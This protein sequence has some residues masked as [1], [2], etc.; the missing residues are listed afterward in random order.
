MSSC[1]CHISAS[2]MASMAASARVS[3][4]PP[5]ISA[6]LSA[7]ASLAVGMNPERPDLKLALIAPTLP[8]VSIAISPPMVQV[9]AMLSMGGGS[10]T[11]ADLPTLEA[12]LHVMANSINNY[13]TPSFAAC[14]SVDISALLELSAAAQMILDLK[15]AG[16]DPLEASFA[17][18]VGNMVAAAPP[19]IG[20]A[21][22]APQM[23]NIKILASLPPLI[24]AYAALSIP[25]GDPAAGARFMASI[26]AIASI[27]P[28]TLSV[29]ISA[30]LRIAAAV[31]A[32]AKITAAFGADA[33]TSAGQARIEFMLKAV[34]SIAIPIP[35]VDLGEIQML[36]PIDDVVLGS[37][38]AGSSSISASINVTPPSIPISAFVSAS[39]A[40]QASLSA[41]VNVPPLEYCADCRI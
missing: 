39:V 5:D 3:I 9:A 41:A 11:F 40:L 12:Q 27:T 19:S 15:M 20:F 32:V 28:P 1:C 24:N 14:L 17:E 10:Y 35:S 23:G 4:Q 22:T 16:L 38:I 7:M 18:S 8:S 25:L 26:S 31:S 34:A 13:V 37:E 2:A 6:K 36:P 29:S 33:F 21:L 30:A